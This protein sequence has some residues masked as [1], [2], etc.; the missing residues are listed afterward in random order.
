MFEKVWQLT[1]TTT[2]SNL[3]WMWDGTWHFTYYVLST[4]CP[5]L[6]R[7][8]SGRRQP[9]FTE[10]IGKQLL[11]MNGYSHLLTPKRFY[12]DNKSH[13]MLLNTSTQDI[14][15]FLSWCMSCVDDIAD[16]ANLNRWSGSR[17]LSSLPP[18]PKHETLSSPW[19]IRRP[20]H[21]S[22]TSDGFFSVRS[23]SLS[24]GRVRPANVWDWK[25]PRAR[26]CSCFPTVPDTMELTVRRRHMLRASL[27][28]PLAD[29]TNILLG[30]IQLTRNTL[31]VASWE[32]DM[33]TC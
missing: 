30:H 2:L 14:G 24:L 11:T 10:D 6:K 7:D 21:S 19:Q 9:F 22:V 17:F 8:S 16:R 25:I 1:F 3:H 13:A 31:D 29:D 32:R 5:R 15:M 4:V 18:D 20:R 12:Y 28:Q 26:L 33:P 23:D 27:L